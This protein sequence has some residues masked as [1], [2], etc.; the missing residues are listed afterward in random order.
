MASLMFIGNGNSVLQIVNK[1]IGT[2]ISGAGHFAWAISGNEQETLQHIHNF[3]LAGASPRIR[4]I[5][6]GQDRRELVNLCPQRERVKRIKNW[7]TLKSHGP[8]AQ[9]DENQRLLV[10]SGPSISI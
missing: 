2:Q 8:L 9:Y 3:N 7:K 6:V 5:D 4:K 10:S 1:G